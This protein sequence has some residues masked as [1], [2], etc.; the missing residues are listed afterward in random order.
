MGSDKVGGLRKKSLH[1]LGET[2][3]AMGI[4]RNGTIS[5]VWPEPNPLVAR[6][7]KDT[8]SFELADIRVRTEVFDTLLLCA[9]C[10]TTLRRGMGKSVGRNFWG[11]DDGGISVW[12]AGHLSVSLGM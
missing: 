3:L 5:R 1:F 12:G 11:E 10:T 6:G 9:F 2:A 8:V 7:T 4:P